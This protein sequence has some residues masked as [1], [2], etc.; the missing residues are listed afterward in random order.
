MENL[1]VQ[2]REAE[3]K[4]REESVKSAA[5]KEQLKQTKQQAD[6]VRA[7]KA[8]LDVAL[9]SLCSIFRSQ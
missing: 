7:T 2:V 8:G 1:N 6:S 5:V 4:L 3:E 9:R